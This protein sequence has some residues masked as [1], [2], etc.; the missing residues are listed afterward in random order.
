MTDELDPEIVE[1]VFRFAGAESEAAVRAAL[2]EQEH[3]LHTDQADQVLQILVQRRRDAEDGF[4]LTVLTACRELLHRAREQGVDAALAAIGPPMDAAHALHA[5]WE[6]GSG[7]DFA[8]VIRRHAR[9]LCSDTLRSTLE[10]MKSKADDERSRFLLQYRL[11]LLD[12][13]RAHG[14]EHA[15]AWERATDLL[16]KAM[17]AESAEAARQFVSAHVDEFAGEMMREVFNDHLREHAAHRGVWRQLKHVQSFIVQALMSRDGATFEEIPPWLIA[18]A[19][20]E[21]EKIIERV[22]DVE[23]LRQPL[24][25]NPAL[26]PLMAALAGQMKK[27][28]RDEPQRE[29]SPPRVTHRRMMENVAE[30]V[31]NDAALQ[32]LYADIGRT[33]GPPAG[34]VPFSYGRELIIAEPWIEDLALPGRLDDLSSEGLEVE[35]ERLRGTPVTGH[36]RVSDVLRSL[37]ALLMFRLREDRDSALFHANHSLLDAVRRLDRRENPFL[38]ACTYGLRGEVFL[39]QAGLDDPSNSDE[40]VASAF[41][42]FVSRSEHAMTRHSA[43]RDAA[44][45]A[46]GSFE[47]ALELLPRDRHPRQW[48]AAQAGLATALALRWRGDGQRNERESLRR[49]EMAASAVSLDEDRAAVQARRAVCLRHSH[50]FRD[51]A[52]ASRFLQEAESSW[53]HSLRHRADAAALLRAEIA[54]AGGAWLDAIEPL[55]TAI[56]RAHVVVHRAADPT[57]RV[58][59]LAR[60][61]RLY[62]ERAYCLARAGR[63]GE[64]L[65]DLERGA[66]AVGGVTGAA[67]AEEILSMI[68]AGIAV[69]AP[70]I[71]EQGALVL[72]IRGR[73]VGVIDCPDLNRQK[74]ADLLR[75]R[76]IHDL[77]AER[78]GWLDVLA[79]LHERQTR[80]ASWKF[81]QTVDAI[82]ADIWKL[83]MGPIHERLRELDVDSVV[84]LAHGGLSLLPLHA[85][86]RAHGDGRRQYFIDH[87]AVSYAQSVASISWSDERFR[88]S[89]VTI[90]PIS[91][92]PLP[93][94]AVECGDARKYFH[95]QQ[96]LSGKQAT[97]KRVMQEI[98]LHTHIH[99]ACHGTA[100]WDDVLSSSLRLTGGALEV[101]ALAD[102]LGTTRLVVLSACDL[103]WSDFRHAPSV[104]H[105]AAT[106]I[107][108]AGARAVIASLWSVDDQAAHLILRRFYELYARDHLPPAM[109]LAMSQREARHR[110][111]VSWAPFVLTGR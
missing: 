91:D 19:S 36:L 61:Y 13:I 44:D 54:T 92:P 58:A 73:D 77:D 42:D 18:G 70:V 33:F 14:A 86:W 24:E 72:A 88:S 68:P 10:E 46:I 99:F 66:C 90:D 75:Q 35:I 16:R 30:T 21:L 74:L 89:I 20:Y 111:I 31:N 32:S 12:R 108:N 103:G 95:E 39:L 69:I 5:L 1:A 26:M 101:G 64:A 45:E 27:S 106:A 63:C 15:I 56:R 80:S 83:L 25:Q 2:T 62:A 50:H 100:A 85:A 17:N 104:H 38:V 40:A 11:D 52:A 6:I 34:Y 102:R 60:L 93:L 98:P 82:M 97:H 51:D 53:G 29:P 9:P 43:A 7:D 41:T 55:Q 94:A 107:V 48:A 3:L 79:D 49:F 67:T 105:S 23:D 109:A 84:I 96:T 22:R 8:K 78:R 47:L 81:S 37:A 4:G 65:V 71:T 87:H 110:D 59:T 76:P 57:S 28:E